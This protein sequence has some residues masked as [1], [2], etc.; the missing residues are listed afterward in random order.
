MKLTKIAAT[1]AFVILLATAA[2]AQSDRGTIT[3]TVVDPDGAAV[4]PAPAWWPR[5]RR[6]VRDTRP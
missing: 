4:S 2:F 1:A 6:M 3:G 5:T